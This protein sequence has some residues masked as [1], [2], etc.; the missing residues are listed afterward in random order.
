MNRHDSLSA[1][2]EA[3]RLE[4]PPAE[5]V[6]RGLADLRTS[7]HADVPPLPVADGPLHFGPSLVLKSFAFGLVAG[8][9]VGTALALGPFAPV[10]APPEPPPAVSPRT[11]PLP[12]RP[13]STAEAPVVP[14]VPE[15]AEPGPRES[16]MARPTVSAPP[17]PGSTFAEEL[18]VIGL[19]KQE[20]DRGRDHLAE[21]WL[22]EHA[23]RFPRGVFG[24]ERDAL[25]VLLGCR[26][27]SESSRERARAF[28]TANPRS[29]LVDRIGRACN[30]NSEP[31]ASPLGS[32]K[33]P[34]AEKNK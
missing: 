9:M 14:P 31:G 4:R 8:S 19:A 25:R 29:A 24:S 22:D 23:R 26:N 1:L 32:T 20:Y 27:A 5:S 10:S 12:P 33:F 7:L 34:D 17:E 11:A 6:E 2:F 18:R 16:A 30:L 3:E 21:V 28:V 13:S 15:P